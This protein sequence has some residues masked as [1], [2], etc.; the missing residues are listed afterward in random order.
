MAP[1]PKR[2][3][4]GAGAALLIYG[5]WAAAPSAAA[6]WRSWCPG[7][8]PGQAAEYGPSLGW[9]FY[10]DRDEPERPADRARPATVVRSGSGDRDRAHRGDAAGA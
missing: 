10:C 3:L 6:E 2:A 8:G 4:A 5:A 9:H 1:R 7:S